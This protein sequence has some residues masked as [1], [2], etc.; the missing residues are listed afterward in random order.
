M[1]RAIQIRRGSADEHENFIGLEAEVTYDTT[2]KTL[3]VHD[4]MTPGGI[5]MARADAVPSA[6]KGA[7]PDYENATA[8]PANGTYVAET[9]M[10]IQGYVKLIWNARASIEIL[11]ASDI[12]VMTYYFQADNI[13]A[14]RYMGFSIPVPAGYKYSL[15]Y[16]GNAMLIGSV[17]PCAAN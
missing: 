8:I 15:A 16:G 9:D 3:R 12:V 7:M 1:S 6:P 2:N 10:Y 17:I 11:N 13:N 14:T 4:G 5:A